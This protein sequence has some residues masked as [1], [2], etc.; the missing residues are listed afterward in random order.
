MLHGAGYGWHLDDGGRPG[1]R[2]CHKRHNGGQDH[3]IG[4]K[5]D[6]HAGMVEAPFAAQAACRFK[7]APRGDEQRENLPVGGMQV[8][9]ARK[10]GQLEAA[11]E[12]AQGEQNAAGNGRL[13]QAEDG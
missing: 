9:N 8:F 10:S 2:Q 1:S 13:P 12:G 11:E 4:I 5:Q 3:E 6:E 7:H